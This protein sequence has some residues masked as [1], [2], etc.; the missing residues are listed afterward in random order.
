MIEFL[1]L[2]IYNIWVHINFIVILALSITQKKNRE[3][4]IFTSSPIINNKY[5]AEALNEINKDSMTLVSHYYKINNRNDFD[6]YFFEFLPLKKS[7]SFS[8][9]IFAIIPVWLYIIRNAKYIV[10]PFH[11]II[12]KKNTYYLEIILCKIFNIK[13]ILIPYGSDSYMYSRIK[14]PILQH[15]LLS[16]YPTAALDEKMI[17]K[18]VFAW[19]KVASCVVAGINGI[20]GMPRWDIVTPSHL[21][22]NTKLL[23]PKKADEYSLSNGINNAVRIFHTPNHKVIKGS[24]FILEAINEL[25]DEGL[26]I[27]LLIIQNMKNEEL[28]ETLKKGDIL[29]SQIVGSGYALSG[30]EGMA[31]GL[32]V[33]GNIS[34]PIYTRIFRYYSFLNECPILSSPYEDLKH[35]IKFL[36]KNPEIREELG[37]LG[38]KY[39]EKYHSYKAA[40][41]MFTNIFKK[42]DGEDID[43][44]NL[45]HPLKSEYVKTNYIETPLVNNRYVE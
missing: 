28:L 5:W 43:L 12:L 33:I 18:K 10:I 26:K 13:T 25:I 24:E 21:C 23:H 29:I 2:V 30:I 27:E 7:F 3:K 44:M 42:L 1:K 19:S 32:P 45:Y 22:I 16:D 8:D 34:D 38:V 6:K 37:Q 9:K 15:V 35:N 39:V 11:G 31:L 20:D 41:Y 4:I 36:V 14:N 40:Q 17:E